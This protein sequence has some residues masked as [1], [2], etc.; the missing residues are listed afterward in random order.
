MQ[1]H[2]VKCG[3]WLL[4]CLVRSSFYFLASCSP[5]NPSH[6]EYLLKS[7]R[8]YVEKVIEYSNQKN[9][10][11]LVLLHALKS[12][13]PLIQSRLLRVHVPCTLIWSTKTI[14]TKQINA[15]PVT[16]EYASNANLHSDNS[17]ATLCYLLAKKWCVGFRNW[18]SKILVLYI[19]AYWCN[20]R[21][22]LNSYP[23]LTPSPS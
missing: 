14:Q 16:F 13:L 19:S 15:A 4:L 2:H 5:S 22:K 20:I 12:I 1:P 9:M 23:I 8:T 10:Y 7:L 18:K 3:I 17:T 11:S 21:S 6:L